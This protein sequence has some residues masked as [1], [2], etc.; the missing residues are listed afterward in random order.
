[1]SSGLRPEREKKQSPADRARWPILRR[2]FPEEF[3]S[4]VARGPDQPVEIGIDRGNRR[5]G[6]PRDFPSAPAVLRRA[7]WHRVLGA[8][9]DG[10]ILIMQLGQSLPRCAIFCHSNAIRHVTT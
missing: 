2:V 5:A 4:R 6:L 10:A 7:G 9:P 1:M 3:I 8:W